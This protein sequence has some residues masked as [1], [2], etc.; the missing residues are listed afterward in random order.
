MSMFNEILERMQKIHDAK[1]NDYSGD[2]DEFGNFYESEKIGIPAY[3][4][5]F[6]R[7][8]DKYSRAT[9]LIY[10]KESQVEDEKL[11][12]TLLDL[13][14]YAIIVLTLLEREK[15]AEEVEENGTALGKRNFIK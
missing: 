3:K 2:K 8:Q 1:D 5:A 14:N 15:S 4:A 7:A 11:E 12:D 10:G 9:T 13:A 6:I